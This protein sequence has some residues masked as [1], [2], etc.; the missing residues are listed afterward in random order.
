MA[1]FG[2]QHMPEDIRLVMDTFHVDEE[3]ARMM[4]E[5]GLNVDYMKNGFKETIEAETNL[6]DKL[7]TMDE[8]VRSSL[9]QAAKFEK[10]FE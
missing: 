1:N 10:D 2:R 9:E 4:I 7:K 5:A 6:G 3:K 8:S